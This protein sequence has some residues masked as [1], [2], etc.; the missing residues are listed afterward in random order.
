[1]IVSEI[2]DVTI[3]SQLPN[4]LL[5]TSDVDVRWIGEIPGRRVEVDDVGEALLAVEMT[6]QSLNRDMQ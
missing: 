4:A 3:H 1:L 2:R 5:P 6:H